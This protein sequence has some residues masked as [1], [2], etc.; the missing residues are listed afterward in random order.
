M[1]QSKGFTTKISN[2]NKDEKNHLNQ[3]FGINRLIW[4]ICLSYKKELYETY[5]RRN[6]CVDNLDEKKIINE[7]GSFK[8]IEKVFAKKRIESL[9][10]YNFMLT[11][12]AK[13][14]QKQVQN[15]KKTF[16]KFYEGKCG[17]PKFKKKNGL[18]S[19]HLDSS[20]KVEKVNK[21]YIKIKTNGMEF[22]VKNPIRGNNKIFNSK[23]CSITLSKKPNHQYYVSVN[24]SYE[25]EEI[26]KVKITNE[27]TVGIDRGVTTT[28]TCSNG[29]IFNLEPMKQIDDR[30]KFYQKKIA[31]KKKGSNNRN[32][33]RIKLAKLHHKKSNIKKDFNHKFS[34]YL[35]KNHDY[36]VMEE[37]KVKNMTKSAKG[38]LENHGS[39]VKQKSGLNRSILENNWSQLKQFVE[40]KVKWY[41]KTFKTVNPKDT[42]R[43]C[44][45]C[46]HIHKD[47]RN[48]KLFHCLECNLMMDA[49]LNAS[50]NI[51]EAGLA[52]LACGE[53][54]LETSKPSMKKKQ[55]LEI[56][57]LV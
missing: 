28:A 17:C 16:S 38:I 47:N 51:K 48:G 49:D 44:S 41:G 21:N 7:L 24:Y 6:P 5:K 14:M 43:K 53:D 29:K 8:N 19:I 13:A 42:S 22:V 35:V 12:P 33:I 4:N 20:G 25:K 1:K 56:T 31:K 32:K 18:N 3:L 34:H 23:I 57:L 52:L 26:K 55:E 27:R 54:S 2:L 46:G 37:L 30:I 50:I 40:Y 39:M 36:I 15:L 45:R 10:E 9:D 11:C